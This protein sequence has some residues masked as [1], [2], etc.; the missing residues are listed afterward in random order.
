MLGTYDICLCS[1]VK[2][3]FKFLHCIYEI[4]NE[5]IMHEGI[6]MLNDSVTVPYLLRHFK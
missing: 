5:L 1:V 6:S 3:Q 4:C 2:V